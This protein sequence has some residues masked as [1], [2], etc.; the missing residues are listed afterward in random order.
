MFV[1]VEGSM[2]STMQ[3]KGE[4]TVVLKYIPEEKN[5]MLPL[6]QVQGTSIAVTTIKYNFVPHIVAARMLALTP[7]HLNVDGQIKLDPIFLNGNILDALCFIFIF[8]SMKYLVYLETF[9]SS[10]CLTSCTACVCNN[11]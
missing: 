3:Y 1:Q 5:L 7:K 2:D 10:V 8:I 9:G 4:L 6:D 11:E